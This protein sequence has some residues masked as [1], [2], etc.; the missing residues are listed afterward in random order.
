MKHCCNKMNF[1]IKESKLAIG[2]NAKFREYFIDLKN[3]DGKQLIC[4]CPWCG[5]AL[6][7]SL[8]DLWFDILEKQHNID[9]PL[10][11]RDKIPDD[12]KTDTWWKALN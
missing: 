6:P 3:T 4:F 7:E 1:F 2:Y 5:S 8:L 9:D 11:D 12:Y 10:H